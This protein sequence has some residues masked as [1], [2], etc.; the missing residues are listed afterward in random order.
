MPCLVVR[1]PR[2][3]R[4]TL[5]VNPGEL[6]V[7]A[8]SRTAQRDIEA[9]IRDNAPW[10][11]ARLDAEPAPP[12]APADGTRIAHLDDLLTLRL[13]PAARA[14]V[15]RRG[16]EVRVYVPPD[17]DPA[18]L[19]ERWYRRQ[20][21]RILGEMAGAHA[22]ALGVWPAGVSV[23]DPRSRWG[24]CTAAGRLSFS[25]RL[26]LAPARVAEHVVIHEVCHLRHLDHSQSF[27][28]LLSHIDPATADHREWLR[29]RGHLLHRGPAWRESVHTPT[30]GPS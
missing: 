3:R 30:K 29:L 27:W 20:A 28:A 17:A 24:S 21:R 18:A 23:R 8:P 7:T 13:T 9:F 4:L 12:P 19:L 26:M 11:R 6:R 15:V 5:R 25:W 2:A 22:R 16:P 10:I 1:H 14:R